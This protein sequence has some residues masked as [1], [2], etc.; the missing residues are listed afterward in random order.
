MNNKFKLWLEKFSLIIYSLVVDLIVI[1][2]WLGI[3]TH[4]GFL[5]LLS[6]FKKAVDK[7][8]DK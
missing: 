1:S 8:I 4:Q 5:F 2:I 3:L 6:F 7:Q